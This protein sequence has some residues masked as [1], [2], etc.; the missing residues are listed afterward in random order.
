MC[1][2]KHGFVG[3]PCGKYGCLEVLK[4]LQIVL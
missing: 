4:H 2:Q 1:K 3:P